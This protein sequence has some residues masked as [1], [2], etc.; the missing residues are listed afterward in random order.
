MAKRKTTTQKTTEPIEVK[1]QTFEVDFDK[2]TIDDLERLDPRNEGVSI[3]DTLDV[4]DRVIVG[5]VRG[6]DY[7]IT[8]L[9]TIQKTVGEAMQALANP[10]IDGKN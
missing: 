5:G 4:L 1:G 7:P 10:E 6:H 8:Y 9:I 3:A 2:L